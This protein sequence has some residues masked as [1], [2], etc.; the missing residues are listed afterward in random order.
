MLVEKQLWQVHTVD[1][2]FINNG[3]IHV[4]RKKVS[5]HV[6]KV[7]YNGVVKTN[8]LDVHTE[9]DLNKIKIVLENNDK[10]N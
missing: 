9:E 4:M 10:N 3:A 1:E 2:N 5:T 7:N 6:G 8:W